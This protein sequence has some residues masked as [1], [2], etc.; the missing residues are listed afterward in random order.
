MSTDQNTIYKSE[1]LFQIGLFIAIV[2]F[3]KII[4]RIFGVGGFVECGFFGK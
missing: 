3:G 1:Y 4:V 2:A